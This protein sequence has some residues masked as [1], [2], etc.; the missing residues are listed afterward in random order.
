MEEKIT[1]YV[2]RD[3]DGRVFFYTEKPRKLSKVWYGG[4]L[5]FPQLFPQVKWEDEAP[6]EVE[7]TIKIKE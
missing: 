5:R 4:L 7:L 2:A 3:E 6:T 1:A